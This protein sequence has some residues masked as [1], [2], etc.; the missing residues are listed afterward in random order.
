[1][2]D[3]HTLEVALSMATGLAAP[4]EPYAKTLERAKAFA[5]FMC[6]TPPIT[7]E[8]AAMD[9]VYGVHLTNLAGQ[10]LSVD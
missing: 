7:A 2:T 1:M 6:A 8:E 5:D 4:G 3:R 9:A 10:K